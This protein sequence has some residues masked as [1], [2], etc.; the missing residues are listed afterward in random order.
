M[1]ILASIFTLG[2]VTKSQNIYYIFVS[3]ITCVIIYYFKDLSIAL[4]QTQRIS[5]I[6][7]VWI[8]P[9]AIM[10]FCSIGILQI[11]EK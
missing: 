8:P 3:I 5:L 10:L 11:N 7:S 2:S 6:T 1:V 9:I 4:G